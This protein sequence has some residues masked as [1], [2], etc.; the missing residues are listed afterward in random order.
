[1]QELLP[2]LP[3]SLPCPSTPAVGG[4]ISNV[5][6]Y[7]PTNDLGLRTDEGVWELPLHLLGLHLLDGLQLTWATAS[8]G[9]SLTL[10]MSDITF[11]VNMAL[12]RNDM[13]LVPAI[14]VRG[15]GRLDFVQTRSKHGHNTVD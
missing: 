8:T 9:L 5:H 7:L 14:F 2:L 1:M 12:K 10:I 11:T 3:T 6:V 4:W 15:N 13:S